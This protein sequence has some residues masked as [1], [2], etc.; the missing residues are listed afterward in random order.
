MPPRAVGSQFKAIKQGSE[1]FGKNGLTDPAQP[2]AGQRDA[3]LS[4][5]KIGVQIAEYPA[6][7]DGPAMALGNEWLQLSVAQFHQ[8]E[9]GGNEKAI[10]HNQRCHRQHLH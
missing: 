2:Q 3:Q 1:Q 4:G 5:G 10:E 7:Y 9:L 8:R 6:R